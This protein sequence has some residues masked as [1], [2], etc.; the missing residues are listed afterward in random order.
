MQIKAETA[1]GFFIL[2]SLG[3]FFYMTLQIGVFRLDTNKYNPYY[4]F[5]KDVA[6]LSKKAEIK[7]AGVKVGWIEDI[8]LVNSGRDV[9]AK[10]MVLKDFKLYQDA[11]AVVRQEGLLGSKFLEILPGDPILPEL[12]AGADLSKRSREI[13]SIEDVLDSVKGV[14]RNVESIT[15]SLRQA[16]GGDTGANRIQDAIVYFG[17]AA[18]KI[19]GAT[20]TLERMVMRNEENVNAIMTDVRV[21]MEELKDRIPQLTNNIAAVAEKLNTTVLPQMSSDFHRIANGLSDDFLPRVSQSAQRL[22][23][24]VD[25]V[26]RVVERL[27]ENAGTSIQNI[28][29]ITNKINTGKGLLGKIV[30]EDD[31]YQDIRAAA[32]SLK[33]TLAK[34]D[35]YVFIVDTHFES[36]RGISDGSHG[37]KDNKGYLNLRIHPS[38]DQY[39]LIGAAFS[40][41]GYVKRRATTYRYCD[42]EHK[43]ISCSDDIRQSCDSKL[44]GKA[45]VERVKQ[46]RNSAAINLQFAKIF[47]DS[48]AARV[49]LFEGTFGG[50]VDWAIPFDND[51][52]KW[53][54]TLEIFDFTG[55]NRLCHDTRPHL[56]WLN[57]MYLAPNMYFAWGLD[58]FASKFTKSGFVGAGIRFA[59]TDFKNI[60][61]ANTCG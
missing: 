56:K 6:G 1:V 21:I 19:A 25:N 16:I 40:Q 48:V 61:T 12:P 14:V 44:E 11:Q 33:N 24:S 30:N 47:Y 54:T 9:K 37:F 15:G 17:D 49:G 8:E 4:A 55:K 28:T 18:K 36:L 38:P 53:V 7:I 59:D 32:V 34:F 43:G 46:K 29:E 20:E 2:A 58:D 5:F 23:Q 41:D 13:A 52:F 26:S 22:A 27:S 10:L 57:K 35:K 50:A 42:K 45:H 51:A 60:I 31:A 3:A 39:I